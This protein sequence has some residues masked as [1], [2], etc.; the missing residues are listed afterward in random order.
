L[1]RRRRVLGT[2]IVTAVVV[3]G[4]GLGASQVIKSPAQVAADTAPPPPSVL[5]VAV[6]R[7]VLRDSVIVRGTVTASQPSKWRRP[8]VDRRTPAPRS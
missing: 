4:L 6:E 7:R 2:A 5:T 8:V 1:A 3:T